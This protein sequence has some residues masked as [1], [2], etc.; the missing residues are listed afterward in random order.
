V[1]LEIGEVPRASPLILTGPA[2]DNHE[3]YMA[4]L[5]R[6]PTSVHGG[7][8]PV[9][10]GY[11]SAADGVASVLFTAAELSVDLLADSGY[12]DDLW[13]IVSAVQSADT[14]PAAL[15]WG[16]LRMVEAGF[17]PLGEA[18]AGTVVFTVV[19]DLCYITYAGQLWTLPVVFVGPAASAMEG[20]VTVSNDTFFFNYEGFRYSSPATRVSP[21]PT[22]A[23]E[24]IGVVIDD[25]LHLT[26]AG[27][28]YTAPVVSAGLVPPEPTPV[29]PGTTI[30]IGSDGAEF[31]RTV[32]A[33][34]TVRYKPLYEDVP[35]GVSAPLP[36][37]PGTTLVTA[38][39]G[40][41]FERT[42]YGAVRYKPVYSELP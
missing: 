27:I 15:R 11:G 21:I 26:I 13:M 17:N 42:T 12:Y 5:W 34:G 19:D 24:G 7:G 1:A 10:T 20:L 22:G 23:A 9:A 6:K 39:D 29:E 40:A 37:E 16:W 4:Q 35:G 28:C 2:P 33:D 14:Q 18:F 31:E 32:Y 25:V 8:S 36:A 38:S 3:A 30:V 41:E